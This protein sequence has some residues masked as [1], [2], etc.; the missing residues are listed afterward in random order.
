MIV[1]NVKLKSLVAVRLNRYFVSA[2]T[3]CTVS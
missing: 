2:K 3:F 1:V